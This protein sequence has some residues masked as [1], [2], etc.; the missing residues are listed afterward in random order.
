MKPFNSSVSTI[1]CTEGGDTSKYFCMSD[2][3]GAI[4]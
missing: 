1:W 3:A 2:S 4:P